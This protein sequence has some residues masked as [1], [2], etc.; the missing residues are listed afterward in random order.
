VVV[1]GGLQHCSLE[2]LPNLHG[3]L[4]QTAGPAVVQGLAPLATLAALGC[5][6]GMTTQPFVHLKSQQVSGVGVVV[7]VVA[8]VVVTV[9]ARVVVTV[10]AGVVVTVVRTT[11]VGVKQHCF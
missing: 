10:V 8:G 3:L 6:P 1:G 4:L 9:V 11:V 7:T 2:H 5:A